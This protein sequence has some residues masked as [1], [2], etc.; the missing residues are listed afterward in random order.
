M[1]TAR[2]MFTRNFIER[3]NRIRATQ[4]TKTKEP[5]ASQRKPFDV[6]LIDQLH[7]HLSLLPPSQRERVSIP[8]LIPHLKGRW[9]DHPHSLYVA[10]AL[11]LLGYRPVR[12]WNERYGRGNR[13]WL[14]PDFK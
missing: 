8:A 9:R 2:E 1:F 6:P 13:Y 10:R 5:P 14:A 7:K 4:A 3:I 12:S 11:K